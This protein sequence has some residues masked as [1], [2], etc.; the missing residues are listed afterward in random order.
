[1]A[2]SCPGVPDGLDVY[3]SSDVCQY[4]DV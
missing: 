4:S 3:L 2:I 1:M